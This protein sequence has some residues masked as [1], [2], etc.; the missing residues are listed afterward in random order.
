MGDREAA[1][2]GLE[3]GVKVLCLSKGEF[4]KRL[5]IELPYDP[6]I[7]RLGVNPRE[8]KTGTQTDTSMPTFTATLFTIAKKWKTAQCPSTEEWINTI[9]CICTVEY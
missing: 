7:L 1:Y 8:L 3:V 9:W 4:L 2:H 5:N 6:A